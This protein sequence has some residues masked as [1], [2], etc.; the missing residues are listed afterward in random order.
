M[1]NIGE[2]SNTAAFSAAL[3]AF[4]TKV[5]S[6]G[7]QIKQGS[8]VVLATSIVAVIIILVVS[9]IAYYIYLMIV[10]YYPRPFLVGHTEPLEQFMQGYIPDLIGTMKKI[11]ENDSNQQDALARLIRTTFLEKKSEYDAK[12]VIP[13]GDGEYDAENVPLFYLYFALKSNDDYKNKAVVGICNKLVP[14]CS[15]AEKLA[16]I[17]F[18]EQV[19]KEFQND[20]DYIDKSIGNLQ[21]AL[22]GITK[23]KNASNIHHMRLAFLLDRKQYVENIATMYDF[24]KSGG[25]GNMTLLKITMMDYIKYVWVPPKGIVPKTWVTFVTQIEEKKA[26]ISDWLRSPKIND[27]VM[28]LPATIGG[29]KKEKFTDAEGGVN[30]NTFD[31]NDNDARDRAMKD[32]ASKMEDIIDGFLLP[33]HTKPGDSVEEFG[34]LK[35]LMEIPKILMTF[36]KFFMT[37]MDVAKALAMAIA[38]PIKA[39]R[40]VFGMIIGVMM[41]IVYFVIIMPPFDLFWYIPA[42]FIV[43]WASVVKTIWWIFLFVIQAAFFMLIWILDM[44]TG[45]LFLKIM[46]CEN[47]PSKWY[48]QPGWFVD[49]RYLRGFMCNFT[50]SPRFVPSDGG[51]WCTRL[52]RGRPSYCPQQILYNAVNAIVNG[53]GT[54]DPIMGSSDGKLIYKFMIHPSYYTMDEVGKKTQIANYIKDRTKYFQQCYKFDKKYNQFAITACKYF[55]ELKNAAT[56]EGKEK[57]ELYK[58]VIDKA[59]KVCES[60]FCGQSYKGFNASVDAPFCAGIDKNNIEQEP[61]D[62]SESRSM[63]QRVIYSGIVLSILMIAFSAIY[64]YSKDNHFDFMKLWK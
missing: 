33:P 3:N 4:G 22:N 45:G 13:N 19:P 35:G 31:N 54:A 21:S 59:M 29:V 60:S 44:A 28:T 34:F 32:I 23:T 17:T 58:D 41:V 55:H 64:Y 46:R 7:I 61:D 10:Y 53:T 39:I 27:F 11:V 14:N 43:L 56:D 1:K 25:L 50:C 52:N 16:E 5:A 38:D 6:A 8:L 57:Y 37:L 63:G 26:F 24:R 48:L 36:A 40:I 9:L 15:M 20:M 42:F 30:I 12:P 62:G 47:L 49:N 51:G 18:Y 2:S